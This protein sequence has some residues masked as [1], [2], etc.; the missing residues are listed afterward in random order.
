[1]CES[2]FIYPLTAV[3]YKGSH[4][5]LWTSF[6][7]FLLKQEFLLFSYLSG[8]CYRAIMAL[9]FKISAWFCKVCVYWTC[10]LDCFPY[11]YLLLFDCSQLLII[12]IILLCTLNVYI[13][14]KIAIRFIWPWVTRTYFYLQEFNCHHRNTDAFCWETNSVVVEAIESYSYAFVDRLQMYEFEV[15]VS[16]RCTKDSHKKSKLW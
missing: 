7:P 13:C 6:L 9:L 4:I 11:R 8:E 15:D 14:I 2:W 12:W 10:L 16:A 3:V 1:M 5:D